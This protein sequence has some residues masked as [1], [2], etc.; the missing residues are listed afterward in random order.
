MGTDTFLYH[1]LFL[2]HL[3]AIVVGFGS[4]F[5]Y[6]VL[7]AKSRQLPAKEAY[8]V[9]HTA[10]SISRMLTTY[11]IYASGAFGLA[12]VFASGISDVWLK[13]RWISI[14]FLLFILAVLLEAFLFYPN[15][16]AM[17]ALAAKLANATPGAGGAPGGK[18]KEVTEIEERGKRAGMYGG[19]L[20]L[21]FFLLMI[22]MIW[23]PG[24]GI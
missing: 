11:P 9:N 2:C 16:K 7:A 3:L 13:Q 20:H 1:L 4:A 21:F 6:P 14:A 22:D 23:K 17:D 8:A 12:L 19:L 10:F 15:A 24:S 5:V 18:P